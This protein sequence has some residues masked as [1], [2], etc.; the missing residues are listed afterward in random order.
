MVFPRLGVLWEQG[1]GRSLVGALISVAVVA[2]AAAMAIL[3][4]PGLPGPRHGAYLALASLVNIREALWLYR[5]TMGTLPPPVIEDR[6]SGNRHSWR[7]AVFRI[8][9]EHFDSPR[10]PFFREGKAGYDFGKAWSDPANLALQVRGLLLFGYTQHNARGRQEGPSYATYF[11]LIT[12]PG[13]AFDGARQG[14]VMDLPHDLIILARVEVSETHWMEPGDL[15]LQEL[16]ADPDGERLIRGEVGYAVLFADGC[17][18]VI[19]PRAPFA[20]VCKFLTIEGAK[21]WD[22]EAVLGRYRILPRR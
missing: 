22:R 4:L 5:S 16:V 11:K 8:W 19:S 12:G 10:P 17:P 15:E 14:R 2:A 7:V 3:W 1:G 9:S 13:T 6:H 18:W 21:T 20:D